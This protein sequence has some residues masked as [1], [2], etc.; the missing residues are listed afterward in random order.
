MDRSAD[1]SPPAAA[2]QAW[3]VAPG[4]ACVLLAPHLGV[5]MF[6]YPLFG[7]GLCT[8]M[9]RCQGR[10]WS[11]IG[12]RWRGL[13]PG[14]LLV[15]GL[16]GVAYAAANLGLIGPLLARLLDARPDLSTFAFVRTHLSGYLIALAM[17]WV[18]GGFYEELLFRGFLHDTLVRYL[19]TGR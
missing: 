5:P 9:L 12:F 19:P 17:A 8:A 15:G 18:I 1:R 11:D 10:R 2:R 6:L 14:P 7:L 4:I 16:L 3:L 13:R